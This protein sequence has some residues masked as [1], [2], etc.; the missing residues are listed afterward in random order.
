MKSRAVGA[1]SRTE[2]RNDGW[3]WSSNADPAA[4]GKSAQRIE[5]KRER[6]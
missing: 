5:V 6:R 2:R 3:R 4:L 1:L